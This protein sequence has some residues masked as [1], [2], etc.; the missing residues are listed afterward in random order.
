[1]SGSLTHLHR[2]LRR[3]AEV[4]EAGFPLAWATLRLEFRAEER[5][6][7]E[8]S[9]AHA[10]TTGLVESDALDHAR[11]WITVKGGDVLEAGRESVTPP[12]VLAAFAEGDAP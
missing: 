7:A 2:V 9:F 1:M 12:E 10:L 11:V 3:V 8:R 4:N 5:A 6:D